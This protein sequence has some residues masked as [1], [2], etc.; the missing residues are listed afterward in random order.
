VHVIF[1]TYSVVLLLIGSLY[2]SNFGTTLSTDHE[3]RGQFGDLLGGILNPLTSFFTLLVAILVWSLQ[4]KELFD[5]RQVL[6]QQAMTNE[7]Q[8]FENTLF[9]LVE[10]CNHAIKPY[11]VRRSA[12]DL[13]RP[14]LTGFE[15]VKYLVAQIQVKQHLEGPLATASLES[16]IDEFD[17]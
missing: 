6:N 17:A 7:L 16:M 9:K 8:R 3:R 12:G 5:A 15:A 11:S 14:R 10:H 2:L 4:N 13:L 1:V